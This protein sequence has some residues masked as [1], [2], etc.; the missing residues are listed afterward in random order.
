MYPSCLD[1][2]ARGVSVREVKSR[3]FE[4]P[5]ANGVDYF[6]GK[7]TIALHKEMLDFFKFISPT[8]EEHH[9]RLLVAK[10]VINGIRAVWSSSTPVVIGSTLSKVYLPDSDINITVLKPEGDLTILKVELDKLKVFR[11]SE[12]RKGAIVAE[13]APFGFKVTVSLNDVDGVLYS[14]RYSAM[15]KSVPQFAVLYATVKSFINQFAYQEPDIENIPAKCLH[16]L[17]M[18][19]IQANGRTLNLG[20]LLMDLCYDIGF[21][22]NTFSTGISTAWKGRLFIKPDHKMADWKNPTALMIEDPSHRAHLIS[23]QHPEC[24][25]SKFGQAYRWLS[26]PKDSRG[27]LLSRIINRSNYMLKRRE[28]IKVQ[29]NTTVLGVGVDSISIN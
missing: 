7:Q 8:E 22:I 15:C 5:W 25:I 14:R 28:Y 12:A 10:K 13:E 29:Y 21:D 6:H 18:Y 19:V 23:I 3:Q 27:T 11:S 26:N 1:D 24:M 2:F 16:C 4:C 20:K 17:V 9:L